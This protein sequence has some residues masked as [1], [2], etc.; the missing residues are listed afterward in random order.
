MRV[1]YPGSIF[2]AEHEFDNRFSGKNRFW[3]LGAQKGVKM[4]KNQCFLNEFKSM[5]KLR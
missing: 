5:P 4:A 2:R 3:P 1:M